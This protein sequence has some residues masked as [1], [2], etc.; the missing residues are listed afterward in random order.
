MK[1]MGVLRRKRRLVVELGQKLRVHSA[2]TSRAKILHLKPVVRL[3][4]SLTITADLG[5]ETLGH[6]MDIWLVFFLGNFYVVSL[7][8]AIPS[9]CP[10]AHARM[11]PAQCFGPL[12]VFG[13][14]SGCRYGT[15]TRSSYTD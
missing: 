10:S 12:V 11:D 5:Q 14:V 1:P 3:L 9:D 15:T 7:N 2:Q 8:E 6:R 13:V 4:S